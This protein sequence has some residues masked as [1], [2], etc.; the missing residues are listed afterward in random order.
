VN[1]ADWLALT[2]LVT[3]VA[4]VLLISEIIDRRRRRRDEDLEPVSDDCLA[5]LRGD[6][7]RHWTDELQRHP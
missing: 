5:R 1:A 7:E 6:D 3:P 4:A 2:A